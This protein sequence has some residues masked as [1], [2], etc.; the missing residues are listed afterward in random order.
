MSNITSNLSY[1]S[2]HFQSITVPRYISKLEYKYKKE[3][4]RREV[5]FWKL[6]FLG[7]P[8]LCMYMDWWTFSHILW[9]NAFVCINDIKLDVFL[10][11]TFSSMNRYL[12]FP[13]SIARSDIHITFTAQVIG[14]VKKINKYKKMNRLNKNPRCKDGCILQ[15]SNYHVWIYVWIYHNA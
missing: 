4:T 2:Q 8:L 1:K 6:P 3:R 5:Y 12:Y 13:L 11:R 14:S 9:E 15:L 10:W 7:L